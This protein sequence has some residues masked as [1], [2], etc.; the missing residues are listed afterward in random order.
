MGAE[1]FEV[2]FRQFRQ[3]VRVDL[4]FAKL[5]FVAP[6]AEAPKPL[7]HILYAD[8]PLTGRLAPSR[9]RVS[10][11]RRGRKPVA[12]GCSALPYGLRLA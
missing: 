11:S 12:P 2:C 3:N 7:A 5:G 10:S 6:K 9:T 1:P 4:M 8:R